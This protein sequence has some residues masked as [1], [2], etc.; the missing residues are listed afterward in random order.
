MALESI[1]QIENNGERFFLDP[2]FQ[3]FGQLDAEAVKKGDTVFAFDHDIAGNFETGIDQGFVFLP[4]FRPGKRGFVAEVNGFVPGEETHRVGN[5][6]SFG[7]D[8]LEDVDF[9][10]VRGGSA[11]PKQGVRHEVERDFVEVHDSAF[12]FGLVKKPVEEAAVFDVVEGQTRRPR[13][14]S[15]AAARMNLLHRISEPASIRRPPD[16]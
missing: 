3:L 8:E 7:S 12:D 6:D 11:F 5:V 14:S 13:D 9:G 1:L 4:E 16:V 2:A 15:L 10:I